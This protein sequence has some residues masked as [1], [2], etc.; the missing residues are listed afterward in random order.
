MSVVTREEFPLSR[1]SRIIVNRSHKRVEKCRFG[2]SELLIP[3]ESG[4]KELLYDISF[5]TVNNAKVKL[6]PHNVRC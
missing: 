3:T 1:W 6:W 4:I 5:K 2:H